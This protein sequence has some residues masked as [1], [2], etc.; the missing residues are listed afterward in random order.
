MWLL[1]RDMGQRVQD[2]HETFVCTQERAKRL[3]VGN[4]RNRLLI[5]LHVMKIKRLVDLLEYETGNGPLV[6]VYGQM[7]RIVEGNVVLKRH[8]CVRM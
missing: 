8:V 2:Q 4:H 6:V 1:Q 5:N 7:T 3:D